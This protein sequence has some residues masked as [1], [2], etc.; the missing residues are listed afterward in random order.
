MLNR[1]RIISGLFMVLAVIAVGA[2]V[3]WAI[4]LGSG[5]T[6]RFSDGRKFVLNSVTYGT[7]HV[8]RSGKVMARLIAPILSSK[9][10]QKLGFRKFFSKR[11]LRRSF[12]GDS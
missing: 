12:F 2:G 5:R 11:Q 3:L 9:Y 7:N 1:R 10:K 4:R 6:L 8:Y